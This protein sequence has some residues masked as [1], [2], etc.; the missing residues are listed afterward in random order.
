MGARFLCSWKP[1][2]LGI[3]YCP[4]PTLWCPGL[5]LTNLSAGI[6]SASEQFCGSFEAQVKAY[7][8]SIIDDGD[9]PDMGEFIFLNRKAYHFPNNPDG[10]PG[11]TLLGCTLWSSMADTSPEVR[12]ELDQF[13]P[14]FS[15]IKD[16]TTEACHQR[17]LMERGWLE[18][19]VEKLRK[20]GR[21]GCIVTHHGPLARGCSAPHLDGSRHSSAFNTD[22][23]TW[24]LRLPSEFHLT[25]YAQ[26]SL[27]LWDASVLSTWIF[28]HTHWSVDFV[29]EGVRVVANQKGEA[30][31]HLR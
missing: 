13:F 25:Y 5:I 7:R 20:R 10:S 12:Q 15:F 28:G 31:L 8:T 1:R 22:M 16:W 26:G 24:V 14:D 17:H 21:K 18:G 23:V 9:V 2:T 29:H 3:I 30:V 27:S 6:Q 11:P 19:E 4:W